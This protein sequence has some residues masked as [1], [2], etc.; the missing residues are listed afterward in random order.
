M[1][2]LPLIALTVALSACAAQPPAGVQSVGQSQQPPKAVAACIAQKW[3]NGSQQQVV[4][5]DIMANDQAMD[6]YVPGQQPPDGAAA[7]VRP[8]YKGPGSWVGF[9][10]HGA[11]GSEAT[12]AISACL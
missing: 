3:A 11:A 2:Y 10:A 7:V 8:S 5:Q 6:V 12:S 4:S 1:K 9:R